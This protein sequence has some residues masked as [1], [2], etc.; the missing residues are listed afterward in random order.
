MTHRSNLRF[1]TV[2]SS[3]SQIPTNRIAQSIS[4]LAF[5]SRRFSYNCYSDA[6]SSASSSSS[7]NQFSN[8]FNHR[9]SPDTS[10]SVCSSGHSNSIHATPTR[11][12]PPTPRQKGQRGGRGEPI[13]PPRLIFV[14]G[15]TTAF[16]HET[17]I[18]LVRLSKRPSYDRFF[19]KKLD[20]I[21]VIFLDLK[22]LKK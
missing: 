8:Q 17:Y 7:S 22:S 6:S 20:N 3:K 16:D 13:L 1:S 14:E 19:K 10:G 2:L 9:I 4:P 11:R 12:P 18:H 15:K 21:N 5:R